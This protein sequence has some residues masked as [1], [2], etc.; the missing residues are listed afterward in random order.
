MSAIQAPL[1]QIEEWQALAKCRDGTGIAAELFFSEKI[2]DINAAK[3]FCQEC[4]V[5]TD[6]LNTALEREEPWGVWGGELLAKGKVIAH[7]R[8]RGRPAKNPSPDSVLVPTAQL[9]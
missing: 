7:K 5:K 6:C 8:G 1:V 2:P 3:A 4:P 9:G